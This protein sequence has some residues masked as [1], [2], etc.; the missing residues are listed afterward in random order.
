MTNHLPCPM[1]TEG[2]KQT[3]AESK[4]QAPFDWNGFLDRAIAEAVS[5]TEIRKTKE[6]SLEW[7]TCACGNQCADIPR[8]VDGVPLDKWSR[9][10]GAQ[11]ADDVCEGEWHAA[12]LTLAQ[13]EAR[14]HELLE[15]M[16]VEKNRKEMK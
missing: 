3:F 4:G 14:S 7:V 16:R 15:Q 9:I 10:L 5:Q 2:K 1:R 8:D 12:Q 11:F 13:I 6:L